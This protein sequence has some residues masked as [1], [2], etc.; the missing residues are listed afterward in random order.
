MSPSRVQDFDGFLCL[1]AGEIAFVFHACFFTSLSAQNPVAYPTVPQ[2]ITLTGLNT[3]VVP[4]TW[5]Q[6]SNF[7]S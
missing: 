5:G 2:P 4:T 1:M 6:L 3:A 7:D